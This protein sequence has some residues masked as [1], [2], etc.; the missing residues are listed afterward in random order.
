LDGCQWLTSHP[1]QFN[2]RKEPWYSG[3][4]GEE[5]NFCPYYKFEPWTIQTEQMLYTPRYPGSQNI[6]LEQV[7]TDG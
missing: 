2:P 1:A 4:C 7:M 6:T 3:H 5:K